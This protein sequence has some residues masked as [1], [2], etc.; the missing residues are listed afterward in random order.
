MVTKNNRKKL[1]SDITLVYKYI[2]PIGFVLFVIALNIAYSIDKEIVGINNII[3]LNVGF[4]IMLFLFIPFFRLKKVSYSVKKMYVSN[5]SNESTINISSVKRIKRY[6]IYFYKI[7]YTDGN[8][9]KSIIFM[10]HI[11][12][13]IF[14]FLKPKSIKEF[15]KLLS[16]VSKIG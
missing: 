12:E 1:S 2:L 4:V 5:Y 16:K 7:Y 15:E 10:P 3:P 11:N 8:N 14:L 13:A 6:L 9:S